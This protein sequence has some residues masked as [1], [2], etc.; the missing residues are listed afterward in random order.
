MRKKIIGLMMLAAVTVSAAACGGKG[1][2]STEQSQET[3]AGSQQEAQETAE[4][5]EE[6]ENGENMGPVRIATKPMTEQYILGEIL[7]E[8]IESSTDYTVEVT[9][10]IG[11]GTSNIQPAMEKG[12]FDLYPEYTSSGWVMVLGHSQD[13]PSDEEMFQQ[14]KQEY[15]EKFNM[16]WLGLYGFNNTYT[17]VASKEAADKY[18]L[19]NTSDL[20]EVAGEL[21]FGGNPDYLEREDGFKM[22]CDAYGLEFKKVMDIDIGLKYQALTNGDIDVTNGYTT[23]AQIGS[24]AVKALKDDKN[25]QVNYLCSTVVRQDAL[26]KYPGLEEA[27]MKMDGLFSDKEMAELNYQVE[28]EGRDEQEV[29]HQFLVEKGVV[30]E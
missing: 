9:K 19:E 22:V 13:K 12:E 2:T 18:G 17:M 29:A 25:V 3:A 21:I 15:E 4:K 27:L 8:V 26:E 30:E 20:E 24:G 28:V 1:E 11:G 5:T 6:A 10:G 7:K 14:L 23:D 16:T